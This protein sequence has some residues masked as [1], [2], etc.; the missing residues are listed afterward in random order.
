MFFMTFLGRRL[1]LVYHYH[2]GCSHAHAHIPT[3]EMDEEL[4]RSVTR[5]RLVFLHTSG[6][7]AS[8]QVLSYLNNTEEK[9]TGQKKLNTTLM[10]RATGNM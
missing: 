10:R 5:Q 6:R 1:R 2:Q 3:A 7:L 8:I 9:E 4:Q